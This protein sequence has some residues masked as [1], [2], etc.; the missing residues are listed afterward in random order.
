MSEPGKKQVAKRAWGLWRAF[1]GAVRVDMYP[2]GD[3]TPHPIT[4]FLISK[5][6][7][8]LTVLFWQPSMYLSTV[9]PENLQRHPFAQLET[10]QHSVFP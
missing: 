2:S 5:L 4:L 7:Q 9:L 3:G 10:T 1:S 8:Y 6:L